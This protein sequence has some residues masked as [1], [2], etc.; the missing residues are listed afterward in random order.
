MPRR[1]HATVTELLHCQIHGSAG[2]AVILLHGLFGLSANLGPMARELARDYRVLLPDLR[3]HGRSFH[4]PGMGYA[5]MAQDV[6]RL[7]DAHGIATAALVGHSMGGK[8]AMQAALDNPGRIERV[9]VGDIAPVDY[10]AHHQRVFAALREAAADTLA[11]RR[12]TQRILERHIAE[13]GVVAFMLMNRAQREDRSWHWR[14]DLD[15]IEAGYPEI[16]AA[17]RGANPFAG[18]VL[19]IKGELSDYILP[20]ANEATR[21]L[22][23]RARLKVIAGAGH[24]LH[25]EKP[26]IF[27]RLAREFLAATS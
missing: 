17:P 2:G 9:L 3:N 16:L 12:A 18:P 25:A 13:P 20:S 15:A 14:F 11:D 21:A 6:L 24:W 26:V 22:F 23:P 27:L 1:T 5:L 7:M 8:V 19:F 10:A 4:A